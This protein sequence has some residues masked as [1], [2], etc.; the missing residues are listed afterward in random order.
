MKSNAYGCCRQALTRFAP[1]HCVGDDLQHY[2]SRQIP[3]THSLGR[4]SIRLWRIA[5]YRVPPAPHL[6][7]PKLVFAFVMNRGAAL[8]SF[9]NTSVT[10]PPTI[11]WRKFGRIK[12]KKVFSRGHTPYTSKS[13]S[14]LAGRRQ[15]ASC[16]CT[17]SFSNR[18]R[19]LVITGSLEQAEAPVGAGKPIGRKTAGFTSAAFSLP[20]AR[21]P[22]LAGR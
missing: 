17:A 1:F 20:F 8:L 19:F 18:P 2:F 13:S 22:F 12:Q 4:A 11:I 3:E 14:L 21:R 16:G 9:P 10:P 15:A 7:R 6:P 5:G